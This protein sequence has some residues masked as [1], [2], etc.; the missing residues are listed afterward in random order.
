MKN[1]LQWIVMI[2]ICLS[3]NAFSQ[4][5]ASTEVASYSEWVTMETEE[6]KIDH[7]KL[8]DVD[9]SG[10]I[11]TTF[12]LHAPTM[13]QSARFQANVNLEMLDNMDSYRTLESYIAYSV[14]QL[15]GI[16]PDA[17]ILYNEKVENGASV[18]QKMIY[19]GKLGNFDLRFEQYIWLKKK[20]VYKLTLACEV[21]AFDYYKNVGERMLN[22]FSILK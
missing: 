13:V 15:P 6:F 18:Y 22:S 19:T 10:V 12:I 1:H 20:K 4:T 8:W 9:E 11:G 2:L 3:S 17:R 16:V 5:T 7:P 21:D 14:E